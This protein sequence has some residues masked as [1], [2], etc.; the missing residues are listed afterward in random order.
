MHDRLKDVAL[1]M[2]TSTTTLHAAR[3]KPKSPQYYHITAL[4]LVLI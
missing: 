4:S 2:V 1:M 3:Q